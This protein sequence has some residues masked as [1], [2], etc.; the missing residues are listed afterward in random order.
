MSAR[1]GSGLAGVVLF[2]INIVTGRLG[3]I[4]GRR[5]AYPRPL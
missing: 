1:R 3:M 2:I 4:R 5:F